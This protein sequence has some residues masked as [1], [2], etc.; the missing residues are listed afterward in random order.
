VAPF[1][2]ITYSE[3]RP[4]AKEIVNAVTRRTMPPW[5]PEPEHGEFSNSRRLTDAAIRTIVAW[6]EAGAPEGAAEDRRAPPSWTEGWQLGTPDLVVTAPEAFVLRA[7]QGDVFRSFAVPVPLT[8]MRYVRGIE[9]HPGD[10]RAV[11][12]ASLT[13]DR[14]HE[15]RR[16]DAADPEPGFPGGM[17]IEGARSPDNRVLG[18]TP[19]MRAAFEPAGMAWRLDPGSDLVI[20]VHLISAQAGDVTV[21]PKVGFY[22]TDTPP[23]RASIDFKLGSNAIDIPPGTA[24]YPI[25]DR[26]TLPVDVDVVSVYPHAHYLAHDVRADATRPDGTVVPLIWIR[27]WDFHWQETYRYTQPIG[28]P[29]GTVITMR[30]TYDN[31]PANRHNPRPSPVRVG[32]GAQSA[33]EMGDLWLRFVPRSPQDAATLAVSYREREQQ[34]AVAFAVRMAAAHPGDASWQN[35]LGAAYLEAGRLEDSIAVLNIAL[36]LSPDSAAAHNNLGQALR[37]RGRMSESIQHLRRA[38]ELSPGN[39]VVLLNLGN[40]Y[41]D[42]ADLAE[43]VDAFERALKIRPDLLEAHNNLGIAL[44]ALRRFDE[45][46]AHFTAVLRLDSRNADATRNLEILRQLR[47]QSPR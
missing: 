20:E 13:V 47:G 10:R 37:L 39:E 31:S 19:G 45:A 3:A 4:R 32:Y 25:E 36:T 41:E 11:H 43:A 23:A 27:N 1:S 16:L 46:A 34:K 6:S 7:G 26:Y 44:G 40:A 22:F 15:S 38:V 9:V 2:L 42:N 35:A 29:R 21:Q 24:S 14:T 5:L 12:H 33:D 28:L 30:Y 18:W 8:S 17:L